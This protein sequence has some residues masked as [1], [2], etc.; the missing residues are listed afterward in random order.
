MLSRITNEVAVLA[1]LLAL[2]A[3]R[4]TLA[5]AIVPPWQ[6]P[7]EPG[8][9]IPALALAAPPTGESMDVLQAQVLESMGKHRWWEP[10][11]GR[12]PDP[13]P[14]LFSVANERLSIATYSQPVYYGL[15]ALVLQ[16]P[17]TPNLENAYWRLRLLSIVMA[18]G[19]LGL[20]WAGTRLLF[21]GTVAIGA[22]TIAALHP[23]FLLTAISVNPDAL[24]I[25]LGAFTWW[26]MACVIQGRRV[27]M[28]LL[29]LCVIAATAVMT[30]RNSA[31]FA[32]AAGI[33][34]LA[35]LLKGMVRGLP[36]RTLVA[37]G[38]LPVVAAIILL[39]VLPA[40]GTVTSQFAILWRSG[41]LIRR[42][43]EQA[44]LAHVVEYARIS[45][46]YVWLV[47]GW[48][49]FNPPEPWLWIVRVMTVVGFGSAVV[50]T[51][52]VP[53]LRRPLSIA[54]LLVIVQSAAVV[55]W[56]FWTL[57]SPQ[58]RYHFPVIAPATAL[59]WLGLTHAAPPRVQ[60]YVAPLLIGL[61]AV[62]D[63]TGF[64]T[65]LVPAYLPWG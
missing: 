65:V 9:F 57:Q 2:F 18:L 23:Q 29:L 14:T 38:V 8:H 56:G 58:G 6:G 39:K 34:V 7:D 61:L 11:G 43:L 59:L 10:Y 5:S 28:S 64:A 44:A 37:I 50:V 26:L 35:V 36:R 16:L 30:K 32:M 60:P 1:C 52:R 31:P 46:D 53:E 55:S 24:V 48:L 4:A 42:P 22:T 13:L 41:L 40:F 20:G 45:I 49:R 12:T 47:A 17:P 19:T 15:A 33:F 62:M 54:W 27:E 21:D 25:F 51:V 3:C 63:V